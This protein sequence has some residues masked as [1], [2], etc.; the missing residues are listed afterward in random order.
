M[1]SHVFS[2][3]YII[4]LKKGLITAAVA[5]HLPQHD[6]LLPRPCK[7]FNCSACPITACLFHS[8]SL[9]TP[10]VLPQGWEVGEYAAGICLCLPY[11]IILLAGAPHNEFIASVCSATFGALS[12]KK[13]RKRKR[14]RLK[15]DKLTTFKGIHLSRKMD[16]YVTTGFQTNESDIGFSLVRFQVLTVVN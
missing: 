1:Q 3:E 6:F 14:K 15:S 16:L 7:S 12:K 9:H 10:C 13:K 11:R 8:S 2:D 5:Q 4:F